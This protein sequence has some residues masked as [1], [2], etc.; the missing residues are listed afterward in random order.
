MSEEKQPDVAEL[1]VAIKKLEAVVKMIA[2][3]QSDYVNVSWLGDQTR[4]VI[5]GFG[6]KFAESSKA[7][8]MVLDEISHMK[9]R[10]ELVEME[11]KLIYTKYI[12]EDQKYVD[13]K[14]PGHLP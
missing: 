1:Q 7:L 6:D 13:P 11:L 10:L 12:P 3:F 9:R 5:K 14:G 4:A 8:L 2:E